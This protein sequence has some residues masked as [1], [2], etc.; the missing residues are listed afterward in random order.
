MNTIIS[1][2]T[3][4]TG[5]DI[6][7]DRIVEIACI[8]FDGTNTTQKCTRVNPGIPI[9]K[10]ATEIHGITDDDVRDKPTF[11]QLSRSILQFIDNSTILTYHGNAFDLPLL[12]TEFHRA[13]IEWDYS[14]CTFI[15]A[16]TIFKRQ[17]PRDLTAAM[18]FYLN[19][20]PSG[21]HSALADATDTLKVFAEQLRRYYP[22]AHSEAEIALYSNYDKPFVDMGGWFTRNIEQTGTGIAF[23]KGKHKSRLLSWVKQND[24]SYFDWM[25]N[26]PDLLPDARK[27]IS[28]V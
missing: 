12:Y 9:P 7:K 20:V 4:T 25:L 1:I 22:D 27:I 18:K 5:V 17:E 13:G 3:E 14:K 15:D 2:D 6:S 8:K 28:N 24:N 11:K 23:N 19:Q 26:L 10:E 21:A 16:C